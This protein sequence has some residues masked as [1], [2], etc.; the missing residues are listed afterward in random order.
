MIGKAIAHESEATFFSI[1]ASSLASKWKGESEKLVKYLF[2]VASSS[3]PS[4]VFIDE[5]DSLLSQRKSDEDEGSRKVKT[6]FLV[7]LDGVSNASNGRVLVIG[8]TNLPEDLDDAARRRFAKRLYVP[9]PDKHGREALL[10]HALRENSHSLSDSEFEKLASET[11]G[12]SGADLQILCQDAANV[13]IDSLPDEDIM[14]INASTLPPISYGH[15]REALRCM[16]ASVSS[17]DLQMYIDWN[18]TYGSNKVGM[19]KG[20]S[21]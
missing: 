21:R 17:D 14:R 9:L 10:R 12:F 7:Q 11:E 3:A 16:N 18:N 6:E 5:V 19:R 8:A 2:A 4:V 20:K 13:P 15:F 1:S